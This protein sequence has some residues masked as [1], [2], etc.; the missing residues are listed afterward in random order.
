MEPKWK[1]GFIVEG[2]IDKPVVEAI[3]RKVLSSRLEPDSLK[4]HAIRLGSRIALPWAYS[5]V[6]ALLDEHEYQH[7]IIVLDAD[8][9]LRPEVERKKRRI[10]D[11][12]REHDLTP[13]EVTV[14][15]TVPQ[16]EAW[17]L[18][19]YFVEPEKESDPNS[20]LEEK[21][22]I[23]KLTTERAGQ[24]AKELDIKIARR[25]SPSLEQFVST[26]EQ[27]ADKLLTR[28]SAA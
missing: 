22:Q 9:A 12:M 20:K 23:H 19:E 24:L 3:A 1:V 21:L 5:S 25:R 27:L 10:E 13:N 14:C 26:L 4:V 7:V 15:L 6:L 8:T 11:M 2:D 28:A 18:A 17:L 16:I